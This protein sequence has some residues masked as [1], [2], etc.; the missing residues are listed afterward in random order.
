MNTTAIIDLSI[1]ALLMHDMPHLVLGIWQ[2]RMFS[3]FGFRNYC[4]IIYGGLCLLFS[5]S[6]LF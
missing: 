3:L 2:G 4:N 6:L 1:G 5:P